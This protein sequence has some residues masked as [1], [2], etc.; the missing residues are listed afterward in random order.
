[1][2]LMNNEPLTIDH[3]TS[4]YFTPV[5]IGVAFVDVVEANRRRDASAMLMNWKLRRFTVV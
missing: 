2:L 1:M 5:T 4:E 3:G